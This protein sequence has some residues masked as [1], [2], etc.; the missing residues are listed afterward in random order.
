M[1]MGPRKQTGYIET[2]NSGY[3]NQYLSLDPWT[4]DIHGIIL[5]SGIYCWTINPT[6]W[7]QVRVGAND[8]I[9]LFVMG[10][11]EKVSN[12][13]TLHIGIQDISTIK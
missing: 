10:F 3:G 1:F 11:H 13:I 6:T 12:Y 2:R 5:Y 7:V 9:R 8:S 4:S